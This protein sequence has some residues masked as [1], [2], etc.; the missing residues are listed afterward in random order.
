[1]WKI[2]L[3]KFEH[4]KIYTWN[5]P[6]GHPLFR[7]VNTP[8]FITEL[9]DLL[10]LIWN[11]Q[12]HGLCWCFKYGSISFMDGATRDQL[13]V[14][15]GGCDIKPAVYYWASE[16]CGMKEGSVCGYWLAS[17]IARS[18][19]LYHQWTSLL[20]LLVSRATRSSLAVLKERSQVK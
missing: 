10:E 7:F 3:L 12:K 15:F 1:M 9:N 5:V 18:A 8:L 19:A 6:P 17:L 4:L 16:S 14:Q 13:V 11:R 20:S 2:F